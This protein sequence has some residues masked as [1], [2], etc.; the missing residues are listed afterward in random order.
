MKKILAIIVALV[1]TSAIF[2]C[3]KYAIDDRPVSVNKLPEAA[4]EFLS[5]NYP[6]EDIL[7]VVKDDD[8]IYPD[9]TVGLANGVQVEFYSNGALK[10][11]EARE[12]VPKELIPIQI[13]EFIKVRYPAAYVVEYEVEKH[14]YDVKLSNRLELKFNR[15]FNLMEID[16]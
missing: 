15:N 8:I 14:H 6:A 12:G 9:Y 7:Y 4:R 16:D 5:Q 2:A 11:I 3:E 1:A 13:V 10:S